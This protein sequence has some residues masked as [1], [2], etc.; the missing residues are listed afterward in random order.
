MLRPRSGH[1]RHWIPL[2]M[3]LMTRRLGRKSACHSHGAEMIALQLA[4]TDPNAQDTPAEQAVEVT[5]K[6]A[7]AIDVPLMVWGSG[8]LEKDSEVLKMIAEELCR[9]KPYSRSRGRR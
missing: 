3:W 4:S 8:N 5:K 2:P 9:R 1:R 7:A 6:V